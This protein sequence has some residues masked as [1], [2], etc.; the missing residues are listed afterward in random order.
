MTGNV[1]AASSARCGIVALVGR[2]NVGKSTLMNRLLGEKVSIVSPV[3]QTTRNLVR[4]ILTEQRGQLVFLDTPGV[5]RARHDLGKLMNRIA[6]ASAQ[7]ADMTL[8]L[9]DVS[10]R[11]REEDTGW[12]RKLIKAKAP[13]IVACNKSDLGGGQGDEYRE[14]WKALAEDAAGGA[15]QLWLNISALTG[16]GVDELLDALFESAPPGPALFPEDVL[17]DFPRNWAI[18]DIVREKLFALLREE[19]PHAVAVRVDA[20]EER[21]GAW[22]VKA[23]ILVDKPSQ[24]AIVIGNKGRVLRTVRR[25]AE[26]ELSEM[27]ERKV[28]LNLWVKVQKHWAKN[29][30]T[31]KQ[32]GYV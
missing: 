30:W 18:A 26:A 6:R 16:R 27:Y 5:H 28:A 10:S 12:M 31:L 22:S 3:A 15:A 1:E 25:Q 7:G 9:V 2:A 21:E 8:L 29:H 20:V 32:L 23:D 17:T 14:A 4:G 24:K 11:P 13:C 19:L